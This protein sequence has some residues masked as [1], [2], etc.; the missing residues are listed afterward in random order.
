M[1]KKKLILIGSIAVC[2]AAVLL[3]LRS[4]VSIKPEEESM[5]AVYGSP[6]E[7]LP[8]V[9]ATL[10]GRDISD[11]IEVIDRTDYTKTGTYQ[12]IYRYRFLGIPLK[13][14][15]VKSV[16]MDMDAPVI[17]L[18]DGSIVFSKVGED[19]SY[20]AYAVS[21]NCDEDGAVSVSIEG[22]VDNN[23]KGTY[24]GVLKACDTSGNCAVRNL[25]VV[26]GDASQTDFIPKNFDLEAL[27][28]ADYLMHT[29]NGPVSD[30]VFRELYWI[31]DSNILN[32][33]KYDG[34]PTDRVIARYAMAPQ[35]FDLPIQYGGE[36]LDLS[37]AELVA[38][39]KPKS[40]LLMMGEAEAGSGDPLKLAAD[41][42]KC[43]DTLHEA[44]PVTKIYV[45]TIL[46][47][48]EGS[49]E[50]AASQEQINRVNYC[51]LQMCREKKIPILCADSW[52]K[53]E[54][55]YGIPDYYLE[56]GF[57]LQASHFPAYI[58]Y[59]RYCLPE[60]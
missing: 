49:T 50:A 41:Y 13:S 30:R 32:L 18:P 20:P 45:S 39:L 25:T 46:P 19:W 43:I 52:L 34:L 24:P 12:I 36:Q 48:R 42:G 8:G 3:I 47:I 37:A 1:N 55:G 22:E 60:N 21:D 59:V 51:L 38:K 29:G 27:D 7:T 17:D 4:A 28:S 44:S 31:G 14:A 58:D 15:A 16:V 54:T 40:V 9:K 53:D 6:A 10:F 33:G 57:H 5:I 23:V 56:D 2:L 35:T 26:V 11:Q